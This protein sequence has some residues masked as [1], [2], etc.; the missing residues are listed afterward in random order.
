MCLRIL[1]NVCY[2]SGTVTDHNDFFVFLPLILTMLTISCFVSKRNMQ[3][4]LLLLSHEFM[5]TATVLS[6]SFV[7]VSRNLQEVQQKLF[8]V[9][10]RNNNLKSYLEAGSW[11][12]AWL[13]P[14]FLWA[15]LLWNGAKVLLWPRPSHSSAH[16]GPASAP[17]S[18]CELALFLGIWD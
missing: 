7:I 14:W 6:H 10:R 18:A 3:V 17:G 15:S 4:H 13:P 9:H 1:C 11:A 2:S 16:M 12:E 8:S 5:K